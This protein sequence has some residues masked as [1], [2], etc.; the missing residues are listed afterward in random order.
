M[1]FSLLALL[2]K[3][4]MFSLGQ[5]HYRTGLTAQKSF[6]TAPTQDLVWDSQKRSI[7]FSLFI[8]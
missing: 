3:K 7:S 1:S 2:T 6:V 5:P 4:E 8:S